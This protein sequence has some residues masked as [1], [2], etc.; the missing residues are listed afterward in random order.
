MR[1]RTSSQDRDVAPVAAASASAVT[2]AARPVEQAGRS[3]SAVAVPTASTA[4]S[5]ASTAAEPPQPEDGWA[6]FTAPAAV[7]AAPSGPGSGAGPAAS[8]SS[9][10]A[11]GAAPLQQLTPSRTLS[12]SDCKGPPPQEHAAAGAGGLAGR[13]PE[14]LAAELAERCSLAVAAAPGWAGGAAGRQQ[15][16]AAMRSSQTGGWGAFM[17]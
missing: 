10:E 17:D 4:I 14:A 2:S 11:A 15:E 13:G 8:C 3:G 7:G 1:R 16:G 5:S 12:W 9:R 6:D